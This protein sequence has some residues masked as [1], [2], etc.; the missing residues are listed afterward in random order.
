M[1]DP[2]ASEWTPAT[3]RNKVVGGTLPPHRYCR[4]E[5]HIY[6]RQTRTWHHQ[7]NQPLRLCPDR[8]CT[9]THR[10]ARPEVCPAGDE[11]GEAD[12]PLLHS[13]T[14][15][16]PC[17]FGNQCINPDCTFRHVAPR[18]E[19]CP[20]A[21]SCYQHAAFLANGQGPDCPAA[22]PRTMLKICQYG[23]ECHR[24]QCQFLHDA[25]APIDCP[26]ADR[27][28]KGLNCP[29]KHPRSKRIMEDSNGATWFL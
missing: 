13:R 16:K 7:P 14:R 9:F 6:D 10:L 24:Y 17:K 28:G 23:R 21:E 3:T 25:Q 22:H 19:P 29:N 1:T 18:R 12:C 20:E 2:L 5:D 26:E 27:C 15:H 8:N 11:C 4:F